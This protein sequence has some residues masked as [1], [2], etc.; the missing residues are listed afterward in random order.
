MLLVPAAKGKLMLAHQG[1]P[2]GHRRVIKLKEVSSW[3]VNKLAHQEQ[4]EAGQEEGSAGTSG[5]GS[6]VPVSE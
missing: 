3:G 4:K 6:N 5:G 2:E 1:F